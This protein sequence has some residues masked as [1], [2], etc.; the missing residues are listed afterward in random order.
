MAKVGDQLFVSTNLE[1]I[2]FDGNDVSFM[3]KGF[4]NAKVRDVFTGN[5]M[6]WFATENKIIQK[7][8]NSYV[9][10]SVDFPS[11]KTKIQDLLVVG[12]IEYYGT[13]QGLWSRAGEGDPKLIKN[14]NVLSLDQLQSGDILIGSK[15]G[16]YYL[17]SGRIKPVS[18]THLRANET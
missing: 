8:K 15:K 13:N 2:L 12:D 7:N 10:K 4:P 1:N 9:S 11:T 17:S 5:G 16:L 14:I 3:G 6:S 18:Y